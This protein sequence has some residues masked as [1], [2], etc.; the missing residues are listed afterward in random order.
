MVDRGG[1]VMVNKKT[2]RNVFG[3]DYMVRILMGSFVIM[4]PHT[5]EL[6]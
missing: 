1:E 5:K 2:S 4:P 6:D 3:V